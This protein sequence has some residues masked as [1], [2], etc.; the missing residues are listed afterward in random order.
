MNAIRLEPKISLS[1]RTVGFNPNESPSLRGLKNHASCRPSSVPLSF[2]CL[3]G[4]W[5]GHIHLLKTGSFLL[6]IQGLPPVQV[7]Q[8]LQFQGFGPLQASFSQL[9]HGVIQMVSSQAGFPVKERRTDIF[10]KPSTSQ[11]NVQCPFVSQQGSFDKEQE[12]FIF[13]QAPMEKS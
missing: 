5:E 11:G 6:R 8:E 12:S 2:H 7:G 10:M 13:G 9:S 1:H 3:G 4:N